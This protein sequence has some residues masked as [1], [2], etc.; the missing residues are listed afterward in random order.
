MIGVHDFD[1]TLPQSVRNELDQLTASI[2]GVFHRE[3]NSDGTHKTDV[4]NQ[5]TEANA[6]TIRSGPIVYDDP[7]ATD[8]NVAWIRVNDPAAGTYNNY[9]PPG[10]HTAAVVEIEP[11][12]DITLTGLQALTTLQKRSLKLRNRD[13]G[14]NITLAHDSSSSLD[15]NRFELPAGKD[16]LVGP[17]QTVELLYDPER[18]RWSPVIGTMLVSGRYTPSITNGANVASTTARQ[19]HYLR[20]GDTVHVSGYVTVDP[21]A[22][23]TNTK[24]E[25]TLPMAA[26]L[27][28]EGD[29]AGCGATNN[30]END[31]VPIYA[32]TSSNQAQFDWTAHD[33]NSQNI[34]FSF[35]YFIA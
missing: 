7:S 6:R 27:S 22:D 34:F 25:M 26:T 30:T 8:K 10:I 12:G 24:F 35:T 16:F 2:R 9:A 21:T 29:L 1:L 20:V 31:V 11:S 5:L 28:G 18:K 33:T 14:N 19:L 3:H 32:N 23:D 17:R 13:S 4:S 15:Q